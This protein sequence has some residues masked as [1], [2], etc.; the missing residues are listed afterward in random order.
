MKLK[1]RKGRKR[2][3]IN[4]HPDCAHDVATALVWDTAWGDPFFYPIRDVTGLTPMP[5]DEAKLI[6]ICKPCARLWWARWLRRQ[7]VNNSDE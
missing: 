5:N 4:C 7:Y 3:R 1:R 2:C 6:P